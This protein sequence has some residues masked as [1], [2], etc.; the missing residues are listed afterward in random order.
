M[1]NHENRNSEN[2]FI[3]FFRG[4]DKS[5]QRYLIDE[6]QQKPPDRSPNYPAERI[7]GAG[8][9]LKLDP[10]SQFSKI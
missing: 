7:N 9:E 3:S 5:Y 6:M 1:E 2:E 4:L 10:E 8:K